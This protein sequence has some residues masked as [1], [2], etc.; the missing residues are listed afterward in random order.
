[1]EL[2]QKPSSILTRV[3]RFG[4]A[5]GEIRTGAGTGNL[6]EGMGTEDAPDPVAST[7]GS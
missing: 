1:M 7:T 4:A 3:G 6:A 2:V 5:G